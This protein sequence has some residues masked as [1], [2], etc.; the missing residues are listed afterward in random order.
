[1]QNY[2]K[3]NTSWNSFHTVHVR[4]GTSLLLK[5]N[6]EESFRYAIFLYIYVYVGTIIPY[7]YTSASK[8]T[9]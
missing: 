3:D 5:P 4:V 8:K 7:I 1:M 2:N 6:S 9:N